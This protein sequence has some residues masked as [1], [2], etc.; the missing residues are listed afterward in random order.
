MAHAGLHSVCI[1]GPGLIG[2]S[3][4]LALQASDFR[5]RVHGICRT[6]ALADAALGQGAVQSA[7]VGPAGLPPDTDLYVVAVPVMAARL[8][9][10]M[11]SSELRIRPAV[12][13]DVGSSKVEVLRAAADE[14]SDDSLFV[15]GHPMAGSE[16]SGVEFARADLFRNATVVLTPGT[17]TRPGAVDVVRRL[18]EPLAARVVTMA[19]ERHDEIVAR[20]SHLPHLLASLLMLQAARDEGLSIAAT[21]LLDSTRLASGD[22]AL[23]EEILLSNRKQIRRAIGRLASDLARISEW[24]ALADGERLRRLLERAARVRDEWVAR[25]YDEHWID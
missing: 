10:R 22:A 18:W 9:F 23:W 15:G 17:R 13:T 25:K 7:S 12:V 8:V 14:L 5:G 21:G 16:K 2:G 3:V 24:L 6:Q 4:G 20:V 19:A 1:V 11:L